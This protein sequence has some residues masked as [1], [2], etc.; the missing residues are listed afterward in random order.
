VLLVIMAG[1]ELATHLAQLGVAALPERVGVQ[2]ALDVILLVMT[3]LGGRVIPMFTSNGVPGAQVQRNTIVER[4]VPAS[5]VALLFADMLP[6]LAGLLAI[7]LAIGVAAQGARVLLWRPWQTARV[8][9]VWILHVGYLW[10]PVHLM[11]CALGEFD[12]VPSPLATHALT[13]GPVI[14]SNRSAPTHVEV[15]APDKPRPQIPSA[16]L[17]LD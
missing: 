17:A 6:L 10:I 1:A 16:L 5:A 14:L 11:L 9:L 13:V 7:I 8:P 12:L 4:L 2:T 15:G 3:F